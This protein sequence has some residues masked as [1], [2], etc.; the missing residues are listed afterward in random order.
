MYFRIGASLGCSRP[1]TQP[2]LAP[3]GKGRLDS[4]VGGCRTSAILEQGWRVAN[5]RLRQEHAAQALA[6]LAPE[7]RAATEAL[8]ARTQ[9]PRALGAACAAGTTD[10]G[11]PDVSGSLG[12]P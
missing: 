10:P 4:S 2:A 7:Q 12:S 3:G 6:R 8:I 11:F 5:R 9:A 1:P